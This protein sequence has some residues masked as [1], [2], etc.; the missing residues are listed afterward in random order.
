M[1]DNMVD[2]TIIDELKTM[3]KPRNMTPE[4]KKEHTQ[5]YNREYMQRR[6]KED[7]EFY[8]RQKECSRKN[9]LRYDKEKRQTSPEY[10][11]KKRECSRITAQKKNEKIKQLELQVQLL[12]ETKL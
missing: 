8:E 11:E 5:K 2:T 1:T 3:I 7:Q 12:T 9:T 10:V 6:K 4:Q